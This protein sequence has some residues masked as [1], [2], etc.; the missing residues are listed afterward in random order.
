[1]HGIE[2]PTLRHRCEIQTTSMYK[3]IH[4]LSSRFRWFWFW[5]NEKRKRSQDSAAIHLCIPIALWPLL[6]HERKGKNCQIYWSDANREPEK[7]LGRVRVREREKIALHKLY[8]DFGC[9]FLFVRIQA[10]RIDSSHKTGSSLLCAS[11]CVFRRKRTLYF[12]LLWGYSCALPQCSIRRIH[13]SAEAGNEK[14][15]RKLHTSTRSELR[16]NT[17]TCYCLRR[18]RS[19]LICE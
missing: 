3:R 2:I 18:K 1:M 15:S 19:S 17:K 10:I 12:R 14:K 13:N 6:L 9:N 7:M 4:P 8:T 11:A 16:E 5:Q